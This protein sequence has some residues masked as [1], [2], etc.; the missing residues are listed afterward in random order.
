MILRKSVAVVALL[1]VIVSGALANDGTAAID[2]VAEPDK[3]RIVA[4]GGDVTEILYA[5]GFEKRITAIDSS[6][7]YPPTALKEKTSVGYMRSLTAEG[8]LSIAPTF[9][10]ASE[11]AAP[12]RPFV[13]SRNRRCHTSASLK[14]IR[15][16]ALPKRSRQSPKL[17]AGRRPVLPWHATR[18]TALRDWQRGDHGS[19]SLCA[20]FLSSTHP[21]IA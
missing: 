1:P 8:V 5:L 9:I 18:H 20:S 6:S 19:G 7:K 4:I 2:T 3:S 12:P 21:L 15:R 14:T 11:G 17:S 16:K 13:R 10:I